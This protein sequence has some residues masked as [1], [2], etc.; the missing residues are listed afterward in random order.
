MNNEKRQ[1]AHHSPAPNAASS[2]KRQVQ[3]QFQTKLPDLNTI[4]T[5]LMK[6]LNDFTNNR[7]KKYSTNDLHEVLFKKM[8]AVRDKQEKIAKNHFEQD[9]RLTESK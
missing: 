5:D 8:D 6:L 7:L 1:H 2:S 4:E 9:S 3:H